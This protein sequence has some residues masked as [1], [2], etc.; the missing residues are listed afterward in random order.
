[1][2]EIQCMVRV[3][4]LTSETFESHRGLRQGDGIS[5]LLINIVLEGVIRSVGV[6]NGGNSR[7]KSSKYFGSILVLVVY[8]I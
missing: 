2:N 5:C 7:R 3:S 6:D 4:N 1:M 8:S